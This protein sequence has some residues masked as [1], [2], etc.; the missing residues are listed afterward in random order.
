MLTDAYCL[1]QSKNCSKNY[2]KILKG[3]QGA[4]KNSNFRVKMTPSLKSI[5]RL[6]IRLELS[7]IV[8]YNAVYHNDSENLKKR[9]LKKYL[10]GEL[11]P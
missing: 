1:V 5:N 2:Q 11:R 6:P 9:K 3:G 7:E 4:L 10:G 8:F